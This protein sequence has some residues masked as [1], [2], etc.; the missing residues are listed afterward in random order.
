MAARIA[1]VHGREVLDSRGAPTV[2]AEVEL[3]RGIRVVASVPAGASRGKH[4]ALELRDGDRRRYRG[5]GVRRAVANVNEEI[6]PALAGFDALDQ[7]AIDARLVE[8]DGTEGKT[9]LGANATLAVSLAAARA[10][11]AARGVSLWRSLL[12]GRSPVLPLPM[13]NVISG[14]LHA[15]RNI[16]VQDFLAVPVGASS[17]SEA[18]E[19]VAA[20]RASTGTL[21]EARGHSTLKADEG[22]FGPALGANVEALELLCRAAEQAGL[23]PGRDVAFAI[24]VAAS[25][26][27]DAASGRY[28]LEADGRLIDASELVDL[29]EAWSRSFP[30]VS[31][32]DALAEDDWAGW[33]ELTGRLGSRLQL[34]GDDLFVTS[35]ARLEHGIASGVANAILVKMN[36]VGTLT[37]TLAVVERAAAAGYAS[38]IS[39]RSG[40]TEDSFLADLAVATGAGQVKIGSLAQ[41]DRLAKYNQLL[42]IEEELGDDAVFAGRAA[43]KPGAHAA[44]LDVLP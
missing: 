42:R 40:E 11:A 36:Q 15:G 21:L 30:L 22:G 31:V 37:E 16:D 43:L 4:E 1:G 14:G 29:L 26:L 10:A 44:A 9:R 34:L 13:V 38:V 12:D 20:L 18:L 28:R 24:D 17:F 41:S 35:R 3:V 2:E 23:E 19:L 27:V 6:A 39:A 25:Q 33:A 7:V 32:E 5:L 8:L